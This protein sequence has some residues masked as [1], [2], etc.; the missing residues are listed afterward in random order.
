MGLRQNCDRPSGDPCQVND[1]A[2]EC[3]KLITS[4]QVGCRA[5]TEFFD[6]GRKVDDFA[7]CKVSAGDK[8]GH[9]LGFCGWHQMNAFCSSAVR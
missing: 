5:F 3:A 9:F 7:S 2:L 1:S 8:F 4:L 6:A